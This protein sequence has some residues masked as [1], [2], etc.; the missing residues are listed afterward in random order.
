MTKVSVIGAGPA[1]LIF[2]YA[3]LRN[4]HDVPIYSDRTAD[5]WLN[6]SAPTGTA[7][8]YPDVIDI[9]RDLGMDFWS[10]DMHAGGGALIDYK[11]TIAGKQR[12]VIAGRMGDRPH[13]T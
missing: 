10:Q 2:S 1:G 11:Q 5:Q 12:M 3:L 7:Y 4:G 8:L 13:A 9:E 6:H